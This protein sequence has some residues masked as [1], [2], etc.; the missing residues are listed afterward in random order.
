MILGC[1]DVTSVESTN[2]AFEPIYHARLDSTHMCF[3]EENYMDPK[4]I[5]NKN[6]ASDGQRGEN[7]SHHRALLLLHYCHREVDVVDT[8]PCE[9]RGDWETN[10]LI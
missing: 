7:K 6:R 5:A 2:P 10:V 4:V 1:E 9:S 3:D 8:A